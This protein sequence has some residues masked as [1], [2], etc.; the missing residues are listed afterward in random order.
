MSYTPIRQK[1]FKHDDFEKV[2]EELKNII[3]RINEL[4]ALQRD[5]AP[6]S[7][8]RGAFWVYNNSGTMEVHARNFQDNTWDKI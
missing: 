2:T 4:F 7:K 1:H 5:R 3:D 6:H 8:D